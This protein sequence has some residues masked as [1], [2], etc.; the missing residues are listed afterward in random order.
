MLL[1]IDEIVIAR[2]PKA[3]AAIQ[4]SPGALCSPGLLRS[5]RNDEPG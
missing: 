5:A 3:D 4:E 2:R 1:H